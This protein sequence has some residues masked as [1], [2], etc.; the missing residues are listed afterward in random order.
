M[1][2]ADRIFRNYGTRRLVKSGGA[3]APSSNILATDTHED[4]DGNTSHSWGFSGLV[5]GTLIFIVTGHNGG[6][7]GAF[8]S[9][10]ADG[11]AM[12]EFRNAGIFTADDRIGLYAIEGHTGTTSTITF[13][14]PSAGTKMFGAV[15]II[16]ATYTIA[17]MTNMTL[18]TGT[19]TTPS[20]VGNR[21]PDQ[22][23]IH[24]ITSKN[25]GNGMTWD[26][27]LTSP[28]GF[29]LNADIR[30]RSVAYEECTT[31]EVSSTIGGTLDISADWG[32]AGLECAA[33]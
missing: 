31:T 3:A 20:H 32:M 14:T 28:A 13:T 29:N 1:G 23:N 10:E 7:I 30:C 17:N 8:A 18:T 15:I 2:R 25:G 22:V 5:S 24:F 27:E 12:T 21:N 16:P 11:S 6:N 26:A 4:N 9:V 33:P 19:S